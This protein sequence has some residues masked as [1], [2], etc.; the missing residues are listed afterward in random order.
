MVTQHDA[1]VDGSKV[2][3]VPGMRYT[4]RKLFQCMLVVSANDA[5]DA[6][7]QAN[8]GTAQ[9]LRDM[10]ATAR[11]L[12]ADDT[13]AKT[14]SGLDGNGESS[15]AY[16]LALIARAGLQLPA[17]RKYI[18]T[19]RS[20]VPA[21]HH[22]HFQ[23]FTHN[24]LLT[25]YRGAI[26]VKN[27]YTVAAQ[28]TYIGAATRGGQ[29]ILVTLMHANPDFWPMARALLNWGFQ[30]TGK[31]TPVG[32]LVGPR[33]P[34]THHAPAAQ[35]AVQLVGHHSGFGLSP[36]TFATTG[37]AFVA[38]GAVVTRRRQ[39]RRRRRLRYRLP[40]R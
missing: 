31:V 13:V 21:P 5:A 3:L 29:T 18:G 19:V 1:G 14:P 40:P 2:G 16:D 34:P 8:G 26:G 28:G 6:L 33:Q 30:A 35:P 23:I 7:A 24:Y 4:V 25:S 10:N 27:G 9:T 32:T 12:Q 11:Y 22:K 17:F 39:V 37:V 38:V 20:T 36:V 15:S